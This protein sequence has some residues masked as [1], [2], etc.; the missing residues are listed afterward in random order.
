MQWQRN[1]NTKLHENTNFCENA[2]IETCWHVDIDVHV[3]FV[4]WGQPVCSEKPLKLVHGQ[5][6]IVVYGLI[7][8]TKN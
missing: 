4:K 5:I 3:G 2:L 6:H 8:A 1:E 7:W